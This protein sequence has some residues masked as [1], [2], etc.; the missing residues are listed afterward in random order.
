MKYSPSCS[1]SVRRPPSGAVVS[2]K[3]RK[4]FTDRFPAAPGPRAFNRSRRF[5]YFAIAGFGFVL[6]WKLPTASRALQPTRQ[7]RKT[8]MTEPTHI[9]GK[10]PDREIPADQIG[11]LE[12]AAEE[13]GGRTSPFW[14]KCWSCHQF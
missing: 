10:K 2:A 12:V 7:Q 3:V 1:C 8:A 14:V 6:I 13:A 4:G 11:K 5:F 9:E